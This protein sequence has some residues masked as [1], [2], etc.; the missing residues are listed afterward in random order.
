[1]RFFKKKE[2][3]LD[4]YAIEQCNS[5]SRISKRPFQE[6]D[7]VFK[8]MGKCTSCDNGQMMIGKIFGE[9]FK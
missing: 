9:V 4:P 2:E 3:I 6:G 5:C 8:I 7:Y 1:M